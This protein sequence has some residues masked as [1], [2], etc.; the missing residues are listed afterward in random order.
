MW[1]Y[2]PGL[3]LIVLV[4]YAYVKQLFQRTRRKIQ[5]AKK[6]SVQQMSKKQMKKKAKKRRK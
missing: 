1:R 6:T 3:G 5:P 2:L 4:D